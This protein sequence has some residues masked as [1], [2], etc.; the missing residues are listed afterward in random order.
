METENA[1]NRQP[2]VIEGRILT[3]PTAIE[4]QV[5]DAGV[6]EHVAQAD[7]VP[8]GDNEEPGS[9]PVTQTANESTAFTANSSDSAAE[10]NAGSAEAPDRANDNQQ[11]FDALEA[12]TSLLVGGAIEGTS[13]LVSRLQKYQELIQEE[14]AEAEEGEA[15]SE[16]ISEDELVRLRYAAVGFIFDAQAAFRRNVTVWAKVADR[17]ARLTSRAAEP[18]TNSFVFNPLRRRYNDL[19]R[20][21]EESLARWIA[22]GRTAE[23]PSRQLARR[24]Y[25]E[26]VDEFIDR[27]AE[28]PELQSVITQQSMGVA[29]DIRD[30]VR[31]RTVTGDNMVEALVRRILR[32]KPRAQLPAPPQ[33]V[34]RWA[35]LTLE[36]YRALS[37]ADETKDNSS[38]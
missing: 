9:S 17:S 6:D 31:E 20:R 14:A 36:E 30:E 21:G 34:Q 29:S 18:V 19:V 15:A 33:D 13:Q 7:E 27:L 10:S 12:I 8:T 24:T 16:D 5:P 4:A 22:D 25:V 26:I 1:N 3:T 32:R 23:G 37:L 38:A 2:V 35:G 11:D 28:N